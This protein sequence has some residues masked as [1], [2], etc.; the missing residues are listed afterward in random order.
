[1]MDFPPDTLRDLRVSYD[2]DN[3]VEESAPA[4]PR[5]LFQAWLK[6]ALEHQLPEPNAMTLATIGEDG[7]PSART[8]LLK[9]LDSKGFHFFTNYESRKAREIAANP[10]ASAVFLWTQRHH[11]VCVRGFIK[12]LPREETESY[13]ATR[14]AGHQIGAWVSEQSRV[15]PGR[16]WLEAREA[17]MRARFGEGPI[18]CPPHWG[19]YALV[20]DEFEFWQ[21]RVSRLHDRLRYTREGAGWKIERLSP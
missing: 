6:D 7:G 3:L 11:Q 18:P 1:M 10:R 13:F 12:K 15:I 5:V 9:G 20:P 16:A 14:P 2:L 19:G 17:E 21:G 8:V 4:D